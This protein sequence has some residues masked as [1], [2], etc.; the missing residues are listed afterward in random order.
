MGVIIWREAT[1]IPRE[2]KKVDCWW[3]YTAVANK[4]KFIVTCKQWVMDS[5]VGWGGEQSI[6]VVVFY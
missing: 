6:G 3:Q 5:F 2:K 4:R 1:Y